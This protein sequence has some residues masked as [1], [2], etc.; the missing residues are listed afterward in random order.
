MSTFSIRYHLICMHLLSNQHKLFNKCFPLFNLNSNIDK[1]YAIL[2]AITIQK[3]LAFMR[4]VLH[5]S[6][7]LL[8]MRK[9]A[10]KISGSSCTNRL[11]HFQ[12]ACLLAPI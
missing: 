9:T 7:R 4:I 3:S 6:V 11:T 10:I 8:P 1:K 12:T 2:T 5:L